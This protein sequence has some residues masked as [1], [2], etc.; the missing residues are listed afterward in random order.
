MEKIFLEVYEKENEKSMFF[1]HS[2]TLVP[3][4]GSQ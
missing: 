2:G 4:L 1:I 3:V